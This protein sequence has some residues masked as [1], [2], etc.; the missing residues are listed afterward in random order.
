MAN[1][2]TLDI[3]IITALS[4]ILVSLLVWELVE[5]Y[6]DYRLRKR[7]ERYNKLVKYRRKPLLL[8]KHDMD[9]IRQYMENHNKYSA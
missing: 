2:T 6:Q 5:D 1:M 7:E 4:T 9:N 3:V 8:D